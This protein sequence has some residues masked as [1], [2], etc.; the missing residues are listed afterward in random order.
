MRCQLVEVHQPGARQK[1]K[2]SRFM[3]V[4]LPQCFKNSQTEKPDIMVSALVFANVCAAAGD[5]LSFPIV[6]YLEPFAHAHTRTHTPYQVCQST[7]LSVRALWSKVSCHWLNMRSW[8][9]SLSAQHRCHVRA[10]VSEYA[11]ELCISHS[12]LLL[13]E[14][15]NG[16]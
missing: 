3:P 8:I 6:R 15:F 10:R 9:P 4:K 13:P 11:H 16:I 5:P 14:I 1:G 7:S 12:L 2:R